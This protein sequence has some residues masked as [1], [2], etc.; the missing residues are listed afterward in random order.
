MVFRRNPPYVDG[1]GRSTLAQLIAA[2]NRTV[3]EKRPAFPTKYP[4]EIDEDV[5]VTLRRAGLD[6]GSVL[7][8][9]RR[10]TLRTVPLLH[11]GGYPEDVTARTHPANL[12]LFR[13]LLDLSGMGIAAVDFR[14]EAVD[15][16]WNEQRFGILEFNSRPNFSD[17]HGHP[18]IEAIVRLAA[19]H[20]ETVRLPT[21][22]VVDPRPGDG[23]ADLR[24]RIAADDRPFAVAASDGLWLGG[25]QV[26]G[27]A[28][29]RARAH[30]RG[31]DPGGRRALDGTR[32]PGAQRDRRRRHRRRLR[33]PAVEPAGLSPLVRPAG[34][35]GRGAAAAGP[36]TDTVLAEAVRL[37]AS[38]A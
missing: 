32:G 18:M 37:A 23:P 36:V 34:P 17:F 2:H 21:I 15:R 3:A 1:D 26:P 29:R 5:T 9:G 38:R 31:P 24:R 30:D 16:P 20:A 10:V 4:V 6:L 11:V 8:A 19:P 12:A 35:P 28:R 27:R 25:L 7:E 13:R 14:A 22:L 33:P